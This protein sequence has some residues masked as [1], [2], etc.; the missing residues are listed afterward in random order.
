MPSFR[1]N[2]TSMERIIHELLIT[3]AD[4]DLIL[5]HLDDLKAS[6]VETATPSDAED[7]A[8]SLLVP[9]VLVTPPAPPVTPESNAED[10]TDV[11]ETAAAAADAIKDAEVAFAAFAAKQDFLGQTPLVNAVRGNYF[12]VV[13]KLLVRNLNATF[14]YST[15][16]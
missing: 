16:L 2:F 5:Q 10:E 14:E 9:S 8:R 6:L 1:D 13:E 7:I 3:G 11:V 12:R 15:T 4:E